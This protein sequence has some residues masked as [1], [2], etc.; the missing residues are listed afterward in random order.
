MQRMTAD[1]VDMVF[2]SPPYADVRNYG[3][4]FGYRG[5]KWVDWAMPRFIECLRITNGLVAWV[6]EG[7]GQQSVKYTAE[8][9]LM[10][11]RLIDAGIPI[12]KPSIYGR[13]SLPGRFSVL[14]NN[15]EFII[16]S[17]NGRKLPFSDPTACGSAPKFAPGGKTGPRTRDGGRN[18][19]KTN[20]KAPAKTNHGNI[21]WCGAVGGG[22]MGD[23]LATENEA[24]F[25]EYLA[26]V[27]IRSFCKPGGIVLDPFCGSGTTMAVA[28][29]HGRVGMGIEIRKSQ[30]ELSKRR[31]SRSPKT[32]RVAKGT[33]PNTRRR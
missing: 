8:P 18:K 24:P 12:W 21:I 31:V 19:S 10:Q 1:S 23:P 29:K 30:V 9:I 33:K 17:S 7:T 5:H 6:V 3:I 20:Y 28:A 15:W 13:F 2:C 4:N 27:M 14:R 25:P 26:E 11:A 22:N 32:V 16:M